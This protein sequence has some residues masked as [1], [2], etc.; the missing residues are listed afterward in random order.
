[1]AAKVCGT[2]AL[3]I[4]ASVG[5]SDDGSAN[6]FPSYHVVAHPEYSLVSSISTIIMSITVIC[7]Q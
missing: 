5:G 7:A 6:L 2:M 3:S 1:M 4:D